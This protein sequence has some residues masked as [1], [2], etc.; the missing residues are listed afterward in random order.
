MWYLNT[1]PDDDDNIN[2]KLEYDLWKVRE[3]KRI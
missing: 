1:M 3:L 2:E